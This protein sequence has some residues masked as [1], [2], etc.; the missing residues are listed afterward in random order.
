[1]LEQGEANEG[2]RLQARDRHGGRLI[3]DRFPAIAGLLGL[4]G[5]RE[6]T[7]FEHPAFQERDRG[8]H[9]M[10]ELGELARAVENGCEIHRTRPIEQGL[11][12]A[13]LLVQL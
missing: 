11:G 1:V 5:D 4:I 6:A 2:F 13:E 3:Y 9:Q 12:D 7:T 10:Q 8:W